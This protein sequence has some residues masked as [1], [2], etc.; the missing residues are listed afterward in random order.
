MGADSNN[1]LSWEHDGLTER[2]QR[3]I[4]PAPVLGWDAVGNVGEQGGHRRKHGV[5]Y[6]IIRDSSPKLSR[7]KALQKE[8]KLNAQKDGK[9]HEK[10]SS[11]PWKLPID[12]PCRQ[13][14]GQCDLSEPL[15]MGLCVR[16]WCPCREP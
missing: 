14:K 16:S 1:K 3:R 6:P 8:K 4:E 11:T 10:S 13:E 5:L 9:T 2:S 12:E 7:L 15:A